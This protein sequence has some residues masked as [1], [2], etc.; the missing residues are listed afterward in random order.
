MSLG[1]LD[2]R[3][4]FHPRR[5]LLWF[6]MLGLLAAW[7]WAFHSPGGSSYIIHL[8][9]WV[10]QAPRWA[11]YPILAIWFVSVPNAVNIEDAINGYMGGFTLI[12]I[13]VAALMGVNVLIPA[14]AL[15][16]FLLLN[17]PKAKHFLGDAGSF[18][19][20][21]LIAETLLRAGGN[22]RPLLALVLTAPVSMDVGM[23]I[24]RRIRLKMSLFEAD[25]ATCPHHMVNLCNQSHALATPMLWANAVV[26]AWLAF[27]S[28]LFEAGYLAMF[29]LA[30][31]LLN[32]ASLFNPQLSCGS[33]G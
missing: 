5:K 17:W 8:G 19:C 33:N 31:V 23:G 20:G 2:D 7:P 15:A 1:I 10:L 27:E 21:F 4:G 26:I 29:A 18:G 11:A 16:A 14:G 32:R 3:Y 13:V 28:P 6:I 12:L 24:I 25:R 30:L 22:Q 9:N